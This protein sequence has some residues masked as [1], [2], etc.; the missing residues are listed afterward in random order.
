M[1]AYT[2]PPWA[3]LCEEVSRLR[4]EL[5]EGQLVRFRRVA[6]AECDSPCDSEIGKAKITFQR[7]TLR[8]NHEVLETGLEPVRPTEGPADF[9][10]AAYTNSATRAVQQDAYSYTGL[11]R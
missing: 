2:T 8:P 1:D 6:R 7:L 3:A 10:S 4:I 9:K 11:A 5:R